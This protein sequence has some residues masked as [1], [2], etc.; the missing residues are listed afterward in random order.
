MADNGL[1]YNNTTGLDLTSG[2][3]ERIN[4]DTNGVIEFN[5]SYSF[6]TSDGSANQVLTTNGSGALS[7]ADSGA[8]SSGTLTPA[9]I[10]FVNK[11]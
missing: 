8:L 1:Y 2:G 9:S 10:F 4:I 6:P 7:F 3:S 5:G 11:C